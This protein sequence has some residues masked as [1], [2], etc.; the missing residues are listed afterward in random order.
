M[1]R[2]LVVLILLSVV[3]FAFAASAQ[4]T[5]VIQINVLEVVAVGL[6]D[7]ALITL[8][9]SAPAT[10]GDPPTGGTPDTSKYLR[11]TTINTTGDFRSVTAIMSVAA[12]AGTAL[13]VNATIGSGGAGTQGSSS[14]DVTLNNTV[15]QNIITGIGSCYTGTGATDG[16]NLRYTL[17]VPIPG[18]LVEGDA[19]TVT[20]T[21][22]LTDA[23]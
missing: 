8:Q 9:T 18:S 10:P 15:A 4:V 16:A 13:R 14:G 3:C 11:Y 22:T 12:P 6:D 19:A 23:S 20:I 21:L 1:K 2:F 17:L 5:H 7:T